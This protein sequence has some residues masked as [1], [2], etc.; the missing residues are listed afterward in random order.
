MRKVSDGIGTFAVAL[1]VFLIALTRLLTPLYEGHAMNFSPIGAIC[2]FCG[3]YYGRSW[4]TFAVP[5][6]AYIFS[7]ML[8]NAGQLGKFTIFYPGWYWQYIAFGVIAIT[9]SFALKKI[10]RARVF[11]ASLASASIFFVI[12]NFGVWTT[13]LIY[14]MTFGGLGACYVAGI[15]YFWQTLAS[16]VLFSSALFGAF[17]LLR[18]GMPAISRQPEAAIPAV[19]P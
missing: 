14:P 5:F 17:E 10:R 16:D 15:P 13:G 19:N 4:L 6:L 11:R 1:T 18:G 7:E 9:G 8:V 2:L 12:S 3:A